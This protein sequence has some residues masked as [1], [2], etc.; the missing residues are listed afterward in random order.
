[1]VAEGDM[2][3]I[4]ISHNSHRILL[5]ICFFWIKKNGRN[6]PFSM[7][8]CNFVTDTIPFMSLK[9]YDLVF[10]DNIEITSFYLN[11]NME[12]SP[13]YIVSLFFITQYNLHTKLSSTETRVSK[14]ESINT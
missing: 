14:T 9:E 3:L 11:G 5:Y 7:S 6:S 2:V 8:P 1:M 13:F 4:A 12:L 10:I